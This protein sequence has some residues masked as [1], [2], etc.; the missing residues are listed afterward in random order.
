MSKI[1]KI[2]HQTYK[3]KNIDD[4]PDLYKMC[5]YVVKEL[6]PD[7]EY[8][9]YDDDDIDFFVKSNFPEYYDSFSKLPRMIMKIDMFRY[10][11]MYK[12]G[13]LY[14]DLDYLMLKSFDLLDSSVVLPCNREHSDGIIKQLGNCIFASEPGHKFW[15]LLIDSLFLIDRN[16][17]DYFD[18][19]TITSSKFGTGPEFVFETFKKNYEKLTDI[20]VIQRK[21]F[22][23]DTV[24]DN[25]HL[26]KLKDSGHCYGVHICS[27][28]WR[29]NE[30]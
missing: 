30:L 24:L 27:G 5:H 10:F 17:I 9:L 23:P 13:G 6:H 7:F 22:H 1:P 2:I 26:N 8:R 28:S 25:D 12:D 21:Y 3:T 4:F 19:N 20:D 16:S 14:L 18:D 29:N 15:K 11:L